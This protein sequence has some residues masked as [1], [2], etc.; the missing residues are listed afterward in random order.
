[1]AVSNE[2]NVYSWQAYQEL[3]VKGKNMEDLISG[4]KFTKK[5]VL[6]LNDPEN[7][8]FNRLR[9]INNFHHVLHARSLESKPSTNVQHSITA[10]RIMEK[11]TKRTLDSTAK[12]NKEAATK[13]PRISSEIVT[14]KRYTSGATS[15]SLTS[16]SVAVSNTS[17]FREATDEEILVA[18][19][20]VMRNK[21]KKKGY[22]TLQTN[23]GDIGLELHC[24]MAP[25]TCTNFLGL[26]E[27]GKYNGTKFHRL[28]PTFMIQGGKG[29]DPKDDESLWG[30]S[31]VDEFDDRLVHDAE[32]ILSM[33]NAGPKTNK[34]QFFLTFGPTPHL[35]RKHSIFGKILQGQ[36][37]DVLREM[38]KVPADNKDRP[39][40]EIV[41]QGVQVLVNPAKEAEEMERVRIEKA[42]NLKQSASES[43]KASALGK[44][45]PSKQPVIAKPTTSAAPA[46]GKYL[47]GMKKSSSS[48]A[49]GSD[50]QPDESLVKT[51]ATRLPPPP[52]KTSFGNFSGW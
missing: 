2:A 51:K 29:L 36:G 38:K 3:N 19:F 31:F 11:L 33:A 5:D 15:G 25:R 46:V 24:D 39:V 8:E 23:M 47:V 18:R 43:R 34:R 1:M 14:G 37:M 27:A 7:E 13:K 12:S 30:G 26:A 21:L 42:M 41:I 50:Q 35:N 48:K 32:G 6:I 4:Q 45:Q 9:D 28:I 16:S 17:Q 22:V 44:K 20:G 52:K 40:H 49:G 10:T